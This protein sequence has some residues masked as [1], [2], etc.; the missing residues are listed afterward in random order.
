MLP[1]VTHTPML[2]FEDYSKPFKIHINGS[3]LCLGGCDVSNSR[4]QTWLATSYA[5][6][7]LNKSER[8]QPALK[9]RMLS[10]KVSSYRMIQ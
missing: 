6:R 4:G 9:L 1:M 8:N 2:A 7:R 10:F 3:G 5:S